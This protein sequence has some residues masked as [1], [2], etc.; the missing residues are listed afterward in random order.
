M[1]RQGGALALAFVTQS[2]APPEPST[3]ASLTGVIATSPWL[4]LT[5]PVPKWQRIAGSAAVNLVPYITLP[6]PVEPKVRC[7][8]SA[9]YP[10][11]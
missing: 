1:I 9:S 7:E 10:E 4:I 6:A 8:G 2:S 3:V 11:R 5:V